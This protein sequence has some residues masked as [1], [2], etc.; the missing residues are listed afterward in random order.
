MKKI[1][2][3]LAIPSLFLFATSCDLI[4]ELKDEND[5][6][7]ELA[8]IATNTWTVDSVRVIEYG[9]VPGT[10]LTYEQQNPI[11][12]D[13]L[14]PIVKMQFIR[15]VNSI[16]YVGKVVETSRVNGVESIKEYRWRYNQPYFIL[17]YPI[18]GTLD[19]VEFIY[20]IKEIS[21]NKFF[22]IRE[23]SL[24]SNTNGGK[25][26]SLKTTFKLRK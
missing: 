15:D 19:N 3:F 4:D 12:S 16:A 5:I 10:G 20:D 6:D 17:I 7:K 24:V 26:G 23:E 13:K 2:F 25:Y 9:F 22:F 11:A 18:P 1:L 8:R 14:L 21:D